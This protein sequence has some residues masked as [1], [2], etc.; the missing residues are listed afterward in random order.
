MRDLATLTAGDFEPL[1]GTPFEVAVGEL[2]PLAIRL[3]EV[4]RLP[5][6]PDRRAPFAIR[7]EGPESPVLAHVTHHLRHPEL[8]ELE[9]FLGPVVS[10][11]PGIRY[12]AL[13][14]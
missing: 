3:T 14:A 13:F 4:A 12:E 8:G 9:L 1:I 2:P 6:H 7:F 5:G 10:A 11:G